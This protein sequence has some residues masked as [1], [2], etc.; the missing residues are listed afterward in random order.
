MTG[1]KKRNRPCKYFTKSKKYDDNL[2]KRIYIPDWRFYPSFWE[3]FNEVAFKK[4]LSKSNYFETVMKNFFILEKP[5]LFISNKK[6]RNIH[7]TKVRSPKLTIHPLIIKKIEKYSKLC[8]CSAPQ[9]ISMAFNIYE[10]KYKDELILG[11]L[12]LTS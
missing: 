8:N 4:S 6:Q 1:V 9:Y 5:Y 3:K 11:R 10:F 7:E 12:V 2:D